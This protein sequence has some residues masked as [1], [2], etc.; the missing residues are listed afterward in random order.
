[1]QTRAAKGVLIVI[2]A[3]FSLSLMAG[4]ARIL[5]V[6]KSSAARNGD[7]YPT[8]LV[9]ADQALD[10]AR[11]AGKDK[12][13]PDEFNALKDTIDR[14]YKLHLA[15]NTDGACKMAKDAADKARTLTCPQKPVA[16]AP[17]AQ[18]PVLEPVPAAEP[19]P[20]M[21]KYCITLNIL[22]DI[23]KAVIRDEYRDEVGRVATFMQKFPTTT[24]V[25]EG[26]TDEVG[27]DDY[28]MQLSQR[29]A[30]S[31]VNYLA[32]NFGIERS[33]LSAKGYGKTRPI[34]DNGTEAGRQ[35][36]R[37]VEAIIDCALD[38]KGLKPVPDKLCLNLKTEFDTDKAD[39][40]PQFHDEIAKVADFM[41]EN[42]TV[43]ALV[44]GH[45]DNVGSAGHNMRLS[46]SR[47]ESEV[48]YLVE[49]FGIERS[50]PSAKG[51][52]ETRRI[53]YNTTSEGRAKNR[54]VN[55]IL[56]CVL[57]K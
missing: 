50:R 30:E 24:A 19:T 49:K 27:T 37:R 23:D 25:I 56:D 44:E 3:L 4:C 11:M 22:F 9:R 54:R 8:C 45:T 1:M 42:P 26:H 7:Y 35:K 12:E 34:A 53:A 18:E 29:R 15:C 28:N 55:V 17:V 57:K 10:E 33:R 14:A 43:T 6:E 36:N 16:Q 21:A 48:N 52:G 20:E 5:G 13:C 39:I 40:K 31:V 46:Q 41:K 32:D 47:A 51:Y 38:I 2:V